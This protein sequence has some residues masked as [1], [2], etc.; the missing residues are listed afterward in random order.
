MNTN[1]KKPIV[2][3]VPDIERALGKEPKGDY[4]IIA[5]KTTYA[6]SV[7]ARYTDNVMLV[8]GAYATSELLTLP[9]VIKHIHAHDADVMVFIGNSIVERTA[10]KN[11][12]HLIHPKAE[13]ASQI[14]GKISQIDWLGELASLLPPYKVGPLKELVYTDHPLIL[15]F[16]FS[17][18]GEGTHLI[19]SKETLKVFQDKFPERLARTLRYIKGEPY[20]VNA[21]VA[22][23]RILVGNISLQITGLSP[24]SDLP[25]STVGNDWAFPRRSLS[26]DKIKKIE[27]I[28]KDVGIQLRDTGWRGLFGIDVIHEPETGKVYLIEINARQPASTTLESQ[29][30]KKAGDGLTVFEAHM[31]ALVGKS[32]E[33]DLQE[34]HDG[35]QLVQRVTKKRNRQTLIVDTKKLEQAGFTLITY[36]SDDINHDLV[37]I[38]STKGIM[39]TPNTFNTHGKIITASLS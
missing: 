27:S 5:N 9:E 19:E 4:F 8:D 13:L 20:T 1:A 37:R 17:H 22:K 28:A 33:G 14:E 35:A 7:R 23:D 34:I 11:G 3:V 31:K 38:T 32:I 36:E 10:E 16:G 21:I 26:S 29:L 15:Q 24:F 25:F 30:Q 12:L 2:Y 18:T 39:D 6:E